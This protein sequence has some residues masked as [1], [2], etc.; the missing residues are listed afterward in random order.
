M[1]PRKPI[2]PQDKAHRVALSRLNRAAMSRDRLDAKLADA[3]F[4]A[5]TRA[6]ALDRLELAGLLDDHAYARVLIDEF[7]RAGAGPAM[8]RRKLIQRGVKSVLIDQLLAEIDQPGDVMD[9]ARAFARK[10]L[11]ALARF[12]PPTRARRLGGALARRG[13]D[14]DVVAQIVAELVGDDRNDDAF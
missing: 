4:D 6:A 14:A 7:R 3:G 12:D 10:R 5:D 1:P 13:Y 9:R 8:L 11:A 2:S